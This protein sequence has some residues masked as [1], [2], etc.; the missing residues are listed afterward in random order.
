MGWENA[1]CLAPDRWRTSDCR[2]LERIATDHANCAH[3]VELG[4]AQGPVRYSPIDSEECSREQVNLC[5]AVNNSR[6]TFEQT[7]GHCPENKPADMRQISY[8]ACL[9]LGDSTCMHELGQ[10]PKAN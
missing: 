4:L 5:S 2:I 8:T 6:R 7:C 1:P 9:Y 3:D 10:K